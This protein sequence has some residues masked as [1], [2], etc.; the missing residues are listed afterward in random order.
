[1]DEEE[2]NKKF[3]EDPEGMAEFTATTGQES[4]FVDQLEETD[5]NKEQTQEEKDQQTEQQVEDEVG[6]SAK[7]KAVAA[8]AKKPQKTAERRK[9]GTYA[10]PTM[11]RQSVYGK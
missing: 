2:F 6:K 3:G 4:Q 11:H 8:M 7:M 5:P 9:L 10:T 1:M